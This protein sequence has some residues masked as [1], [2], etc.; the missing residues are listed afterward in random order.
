AASASSRSGWPPLMGDWLTWS[1]MTAVMGDGA[2]T[3]E[4][5]AGCMVARLGPADPRAC[6]TATTSMA[7]T[8]PRRGDRLSEV[9]EA[10]THPVSHRRGRTHVVSRWQSD[11]TLLCAQ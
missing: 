11:P 5:A 7:G 1:R 9:G 3:G 8:P 4:G 10:L 6:A 2:L